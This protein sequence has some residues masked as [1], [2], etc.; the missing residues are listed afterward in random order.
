MKRFIITTIAVLMTVSMMLQSCSKGDSVSTE[1]RDNE[2]LIE[3]VLITDLSGFNDS[4]LTTMTKGWSFKEWL[5]VASADVNGAWVGGKIG[6]KV[7]AAVGTFLGSP[8]TGGVFGTFLGG[9]VGGVMSSY[10]ASPDTPAFAKRDITYTEI[11]QLCLQA[12]DNNLAVNNDCIMASPAVWQKIEVEENVLST[13]TLKPKEL[14]MGKM[15]NVMLSVINDS[16]K[17][18]QNKIAEWDDTLYN[19]VINSDE[20]EL[21][22]EDAKKLS[23]G[24]YCS[25]SEDSKISYVMELFENI[26]SEYP[27]DINDVVYIINEYITVIDAST[28]L[29]A[30][31][32]DFVRIGFATALYSFH[33]WDKTFSSVAS[34]E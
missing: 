34:H 3:S 6:A 9:M 29:T 14:S 15:H 10:V 5:G 1:Q 23:L 13:V 18:D 7:G 11:S 31:E 8:I 19:A 27:R 17:I 21:L 26:Y 25:D 22:F 2:L 20:M 24:S 16:A 32:K 4:L 28:E 30:E 12:A 33:Y